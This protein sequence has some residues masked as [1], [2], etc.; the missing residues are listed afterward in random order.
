TFRGG[1]AGAFVTWL[2]R[3]ADHRLQDLAKYHGAAKRRADVVRLSQA[4]EVAASA[5]GPSSQGARS[6]QVERLRRAIVES[7]DA[8]EAEAVLLRHLPGLTREEPAGR[9]GKRGKQ[10]RTLLARAC[11]RLGSALEEG[12]GLAR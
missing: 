5:A 11:W 7:L 3:I 10:V 8:D 9:M 2:L 6:E 12:L 1:G 4:E